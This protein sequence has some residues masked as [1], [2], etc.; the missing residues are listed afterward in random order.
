MLRAPTWSWLGFVK[1]CQVGPPLGQFVGSKYLA[2]NVP[3]KCRSSRGVVCGV[4]DQGELEP[5]DFC[6]GRVLL[7]A[8]VVVVDPTL[9]HL[10]LGDSLLH[11]LRKDLMHV[12]H[13]FAAGA[14]IVLCGVR[15]KDE[16]GQCCWVVASMSFSWSVCH[17]DC[18]QDCSQNN[19]VECHNGHAVKVRIY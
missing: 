19:K 4:A 17:S 3:G 10:G 15:R 9:M 12:L 6:E 16:I 8:E 7:R 11:H 14:H 18:G 1:V 2:G 5:L 13:T